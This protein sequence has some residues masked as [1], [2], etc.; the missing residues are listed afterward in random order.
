MIR[1]STP[2]ELD[3]SPGRPQQRLQAFREILNRP[4]GLAQR[5]PDLAPQFPFRLGEGPRDWVIPYILDDRIVALGIQAI[6]ELF[7]GI[8]DRRQAGAEPSVPPRYGLRR[9]I[10]PWGVRL[11]VS[12]SEIDPHLDP[13]LVEAWCDRSAGAL[14]EELTGAFTRAIEAE[15]LA[16]KAPPFGCLMVLATIELAATLKER[17]KSRA[18]RGLSYERLEKALGFALFSLVEISAN[19]AIQEIERR[20]RPRDARPAIDRVRLCLN[21]LSYCSIRTRALQNGL[22]PWG[23]LDSLEELWLARRADELLSRPIDQLLQ[24]GLDQVL[25]DAKIKARYARAGR[26]AR[27]RHELLTLLWEYDRGTDATWGELRAALSV[28]ERLEELYEDSKTLVQRLRQAGVSPKSLAPIQSLFTQGDD[29]RRGPA[30][31][32]RKPNRLRHRSPGRDPRRSPRP[33]AAR[34]ARRRRC[35]APGPAL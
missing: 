2:A 35:S 28:D 4:G 5:L 33:S 10:Q 15:L 24:I 17:I 11:A 31:R 1:V 26:Q 32:D 8:A 12:A 34:R 19:R 3:V 20:P 7:D 13:A 30:A 21:P 9:G 29:R 6:E 23:L 18:V 22:N 16:D 27:F 14:G 25:Q